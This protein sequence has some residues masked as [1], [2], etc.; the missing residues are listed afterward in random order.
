MPTLTSRALITMVLLS[1]A[2]PL[3]IHL[4]LYLPLMSVSMFSSPF[5]LFYILVF[6]WTVW[7]TRTTR[8]TADRSANA[9]SAA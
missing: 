3:V 6:G 7:L 4:S 1:I 8:R 9:V 5:G 2:I